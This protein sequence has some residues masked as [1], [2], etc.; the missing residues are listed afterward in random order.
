MKITI[1]IDCKGTGSWAPVEDEY[2]DSEDPEDW[3]P[4]AKPTS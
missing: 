2:G 3:T 1:T 4:H